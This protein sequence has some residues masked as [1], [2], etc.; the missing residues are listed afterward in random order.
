M[1]ILCIICISFKIQKF[2]SPLITNWEEILNLNTFLFLQFSNF[3][4]LH[5]IAT[6]QAWWDGCGTPHIFNISNQANVLQYYQY[7][8]IIC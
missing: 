6:S 3:I 2:E 7:S 4:V 8:I 5:I 1:I